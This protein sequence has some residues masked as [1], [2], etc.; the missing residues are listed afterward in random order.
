[1]SA[2]GF[3]TAAALAA[4]KAKVRDAWSGVRMHR[5]D[6]NRESERF[7]APVRL[8]VALDLNGLEAKDVRVE[9]LLSPA[10]AGLDVERRDVMRFSPDGAAKDREQRYSLELKAEHCGLM[11]YQ[12]RAYPYHESLTHPHET[13]L[14]IYL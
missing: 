1:M 2:D 5:L 12:I 9:L 7:G 8:E 3:K 13:G 10:N 11:T 6:E 4:W 14:M